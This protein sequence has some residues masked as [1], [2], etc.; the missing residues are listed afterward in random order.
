MYF[1]YDS[2]LFRSEGP[3]L[4]IKWFLTLDPD[5]KYGNIHIPGKAL[6]QHPDGKYS[7]GAYQGKRSIRIY[8]SVDNGLT[9]ELVADWG[10]T[11]LGMYMVCL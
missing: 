1:S 9:W 10:D 8:G 2:K 6:V 4:I 7:L 3:I 11:Y 5:K